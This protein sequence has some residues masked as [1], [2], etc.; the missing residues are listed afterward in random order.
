M[1]GPLS[2]S[3]ANVNGGSRAGR[4]GWGRTCV[5]AG[6]DKRGEVKEKEEVKPLRR[7]GAQGSFGAPTLQPSN[8]QFY[9]LSKPKT[10]ANI[11]TSLGPS[12]FPIFNHRVKIVTFLYRGL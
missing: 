9:F 5:E 10:I 8:M 2:G 7:K 6:G 3:H 1:R 12:K 11:L 4:W